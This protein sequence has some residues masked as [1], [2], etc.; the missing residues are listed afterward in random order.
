MSNLITNNLATVMSEVQDLQR[1][2]TPGACLTLTRSATL[3]ITTAGTTIT[4]QTE[5][6]NNGFTWSGADVTI[7]TNGYY[8]IAL[9]YASA[10]STAYANIIVNTAI[11]AQLP[12]SYVSSTLHAFFIVRY[13]TADDIVNLRV[14]P[15]INTTINVTAE[16]TANESP[17]LHIVQMTG[18]PT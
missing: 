2:E 18:S 15:S 9:I 10:V 8:G 16:N 14:F 12:A 4:W 13:F 17:I 1:V 6:R 5:T 11:V 3:A 7:P